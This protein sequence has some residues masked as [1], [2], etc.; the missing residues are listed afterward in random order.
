MSNLLAA[1]GRGQLSRLPAMVQRR[2]QINRNYRAAFADIDGLAFMPA[3]PF[4]EPSNWLTVIT[5]D[6]QRFGLSREDLR[7][8]L[9]RSNIE[10]RPVW[11]PMHLQPAFAGCSVRGGAVAERIFET[12]LCLPSGS[13]MSDP[14][15]ERV[16]EA[17]RAARQGG[18]R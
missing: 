1:I 15:V 9:E 5:I 17:V 14:D 4:G 3:A 2:R 11:K 10:G 7:R 16:I 18:K 8:R 6:E 13:G 12:G